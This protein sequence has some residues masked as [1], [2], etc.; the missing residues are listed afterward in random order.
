MW[1]MLYAQVLQVDGAAW[2]NILLGRE[3]ANPFPDEAENRF[4]PQRAL[5][6][7]VCQF[8]QPGV[9][10]VLRDLGLPT[11][12][13]LSVLA[14]ELIPETILRTQADAP[15]RDPLGESLG[16]VRI[17]RTSPLVPIPPIC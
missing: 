15:R 12:S 7:A 9:E 14:V 8:A 10:R 4:R 6:F 16:S 2:R 5:E 17:L 13:P 11:N 1:I 3:R